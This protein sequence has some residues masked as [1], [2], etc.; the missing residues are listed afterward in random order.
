MVSKQQKNS[1]YSVHQSYPMLSHNESSVRIA[2]TATLTSTDISLATALD[3]LPKIRQRPRY[4]LQHILHIFTIQELISR[5]LLPDQG[6]LIQSQP[7]DIQNSATGIQDAR[8]E[9]QLN[10]VTLLC[11]DCPVPKSYERSLAAGPIALA[12]VHAGPVD[13]D[14]HHRHDQLQDCGIEAA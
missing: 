13:Q 7:Q 4:P 14:L 5:L 8:R 6:E 11:R 2:A 12:V 1:V 9:E 3:Q 10:G